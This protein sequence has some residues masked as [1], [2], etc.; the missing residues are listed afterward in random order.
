[1]Q[2][3]LYDATVG[4]S[5]GGQRQVITRSGANAFHGNLY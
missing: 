3:S 1:V 2:T 5:G 4:R